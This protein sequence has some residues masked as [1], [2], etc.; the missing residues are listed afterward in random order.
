VRGSS[1]SRQ[2]SPGDLDLVDSGDTSGPDRGRE[3]ERRATIGAPKIL[4]M[5]HGWRLRTLHLRAN[6]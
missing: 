3:G 5:L 1:V 2:H 6:V 4:G